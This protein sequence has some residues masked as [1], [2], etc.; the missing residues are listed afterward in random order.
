MI[1]MICLDYDNTIFDHK[2]KKIPDSARKAIE[3]IREKCRI[4]LA[5]GRFFN[6]VWNAPM[7][8]EIHPDGVI[9]ANAALIEADGKVL[10]ETWLDADVQRQVIDF[11]YEHDLCLG[12]LYQGK[13]YTTN[14][15]KQIE[16]WGG[17]EALHAQMLGD[18][19]QLRDIP[20][21]G[22][23]LEDSVEAAKLITDHFP[24]LRAPLMD[25]KRGGADVLPNFLSKAYGMR[26]LADYWGLPMEETAAVGDSMNDYE[27]V[28]EAGVGIAMGNATPGLKK[29]ADHVTADIGEDGLK[30]AFEYLGLL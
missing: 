6:D 26:R 5:S 22:L 8:E 4:V 1:R 19:R 30:K 2:Q 14:K 11:A 9:H 24:Q 12:G 29:V 10:E 17:N 15:K 13:W 27:M 3:D 7:L 23:F 25:E 20:M 21:H 18:A 28:R 16:R